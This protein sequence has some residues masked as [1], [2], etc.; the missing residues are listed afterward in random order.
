MRSLCGQ[1]IGEVTV[2]IVPA[3]SAGIYGIALAGRCWRH[4]D[5]G[6]IVMAQWRIVYRVWNFHA[7]IAVAALAVYGPW[8]GAIGFQVG[9]IIVIPVGMPVIGGVG[10]AGGRGLGGG[11]GGVL[12]G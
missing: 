5:I 1:R 9:D 3:A 6:V 8:V 10:A 12:A 7:P 4:D 11:D 2:V